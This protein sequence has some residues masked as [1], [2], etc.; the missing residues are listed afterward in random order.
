MTEKTLDEKFQEA[1]LAPQRVVV[2][3]GLIIA[4]ALAVFVG[5]GYA[6]T[7]DPYVQEVLALEGKEIRGQGI[8]QANC[9]V[10]HGLEGRGEVGPSLLD[11]SGHKSRV[12]II[13]QVISGQ[14]PPMPQFQP[15]SQDMAD[16]LQY[17]ET[18]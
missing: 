16:L 10:C 14:T 12:G 3:I 8:F 13:Q 17:L 4:I 18:L 6:H 5:V 15:N 11:L 7:S 2:L 9:A 1:T